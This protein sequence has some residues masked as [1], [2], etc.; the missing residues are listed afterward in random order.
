MMNEKDWKQMHDDSIFMN[1]QHLREMGFANE[2]KDGIIGIERK[3]KLGFAINT[4][5]YIEVCNDKDELLGIIYLHR[6]WN[7]YVW[8]QDIGVIMSR[9]C[10]ETINEKIKELKN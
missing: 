3:G 2:S 8:E 7:K 4:N 1:L 10:L 6:P 9:S 5:G